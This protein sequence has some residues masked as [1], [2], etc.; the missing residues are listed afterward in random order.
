MRCTGATHCWD[1]EEFDDTRARLDPARYGRVMSLR[2]LLGL[3]RLL[4]SIVRKDDR[5]K[6]LCDACSLPIERSEF[7]RW[8]VSAPLAGQ[9]DDF[10]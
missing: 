6:A 9:Q 4:T 5:F 7:G 10:I 1:V 3:H 8:T 2:C